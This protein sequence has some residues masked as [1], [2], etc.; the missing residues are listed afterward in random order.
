MKKNEIHER[1]TTQHK[2][3]KNKAEEESYIKEER[4][5]MALEAYENWLVSHIIIM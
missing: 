4:D 2:S 3:V 5:K 1:L